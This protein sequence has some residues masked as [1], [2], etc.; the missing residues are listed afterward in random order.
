MPSSNPIL[1]LLTGSVAIFA[2]S[3]ELQAKDGVRAS[4]DGVSVTAADGA[5]K[6]TVGGRLHLDALAYDAGVFALEDADIRRA[7][8]EV[9]GNIGGIVRFR[10]DREFARSRGWRNLWVSVRPFDNL[11]IKGGNFNVPFGMEDLQS[12]NS[13][14]FMERS[15]VA[16][17]TPSYGLGAGA[18][19]S[20]RDWTLSA[21]YFDDAIADENGRTEKRGKGF[22]GRLTALPLRRRDRFAHVGAAVERRYFSTGDVASFRGNSGSALAPGLLATGRIRNPQNLTN[23]AGEMALASGSLLLQGQYVSTTLTRTNRSALHFNG[24]YA[25]ASW[26]ITGQRYVYS[27]RA[28]IVSGVNL[29]RG[30]TAVELAAR[31]SE[32]DLND[33]NFNSG[34]AGALTIGVNWYLSENI[35]L[36]ANYVRS[37]AHDMEDRADREADLLATR[38][39]LNF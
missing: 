7:R 10:A 2:L 17:L 5:L 13:I 19:L 22:T 32:L 28:G 25:Q 37:D 3:P 14:P 9:S 21:G 18:L 35:R 4:A 33:G 20:Q 12:S 23:V 8:L 34:Q 39:Q 27:R 11:E 38:L 36:M 29:K 24:W 30:R 6:V 16:A 31:Y 1:R 26:V 15:L